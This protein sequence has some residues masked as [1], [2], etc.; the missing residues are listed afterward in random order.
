MSTNCVTSP[1]CSGKP[2][3][4]N[5][6]FLLKKKS[7][8]RK[9]FYLF[10]KK[11]VFKKACSEKLELLQIKKKNLSVIRMIFAIFVALLKSQK[12]LIWIY[13]NTKEKRY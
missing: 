5:D 12:T 10:A 4:K 13:T 6:Y 2:F 8:Q 7:D 9:L 1:D 3:L 11:G